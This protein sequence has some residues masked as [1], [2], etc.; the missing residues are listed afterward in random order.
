MLEANFFWCLIGRGLVE[1][2]GMNQGFWGHSKDG[3]IFFSL[4]AQ[5]ACKSRLA[6]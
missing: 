4:F 6:T 2:L 3:S 5:K 1:M